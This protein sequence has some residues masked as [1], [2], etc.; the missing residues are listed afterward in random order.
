MCPLW[1]NLEK[2]LATAGNRGSSPLKGIATKV[3]IAR[4]A[5]KQEAKGIILRQGGVVQWQNSGFIP[6]ISAR[7]ARGLG[8]SPSV[9]IGVVPLNCS[10]S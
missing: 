3:T 4:V 1:T 6:R 9:P 10:S 8:S 2:S 5:H 7:L